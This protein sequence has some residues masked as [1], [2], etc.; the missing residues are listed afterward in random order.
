MQEVLGEVLAVAEPGSSASAFRR[1]LDLQQKSLAD[2]TGVGPSVRLLSNTGVLEYR[3][4]R[5]SEALGLLQQALDQLQQRGSVLF[6]RRV[7][8]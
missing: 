6:L 1:A 3:S 7:N 5:F 8:P 2:G 4:K